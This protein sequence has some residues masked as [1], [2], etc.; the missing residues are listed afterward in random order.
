MPL[1]I[2]DEETEED[3]KM[4]KIGPQTLLHI[5]HMNNIIDQI[6]NSPTYLK[7]IKYP[8]H[9]TYES[10]VYSLIVLEEEKEEPPQQ[11][12][13]YNNPSYAFPECD[14]P[15]GDSGFV[16]V[17]YCDKG[18][19]TKC[20]GSIPVSNT[21][22]TTNSSIGTACPTGP[23]GIKGP[24]GPP[25]FSSI[26]HDYFD[27][28]DCVGISSF[29]DIYIKN[30]PHY[31]YK[32]LQECGEVHVCDIE[33]KHDAISNISLKINGGLKYDKVE[34]V[35]K[36]DDAV[37]CSKTVTIQSF[38]TSCT[39]LKFPNLIVLEN[40]NKVSVYIRGN[41]LTIADEKMSFH[42]KFNKILFD[43]ISRKKISCGLN[44][45]LYKTTEGVIICTL[46]ATH[47]PRFFTQLQ[48]SVDSKF[49][50]LYT[51]TKPLAGD[52]EENEEFSDDEL[53]FFNPSGKFTIK[54]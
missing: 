49:K 16:D 25:N 47:T 52:L 50:H 27:F 53:D 1:T 45:F 22:P 36:I 35:L 30:R 51:H 17:C 19:V 8:D 23:S 18:P 11:M 43:T 38:I 33:G 24:T 7:L 21:W 42:V 41:P 12:L 40:W 31:E 10:M 4:N 26:Q 29:Q 9:M 14:C 39:F 48:Y 28:K 3:D 5:N 54:I 44:T 34:C 20:L 13:V 6:Q 46:K 32:K 15:V 2:S 37:I